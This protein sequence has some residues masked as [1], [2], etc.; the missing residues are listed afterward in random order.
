MANFRTDDADYDESEAKPKDRSLKIIQGDMRER[1]VGAYI[2]KK[3]KIG[4]FRE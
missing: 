3:D 1:G 2:E 4:Q